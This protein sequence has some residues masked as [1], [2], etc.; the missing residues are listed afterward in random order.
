MWIFDTKSNRQF[1][2]SIQK[3]KKQIQ[4]SEYKDNPLFPPLRT[5]RYY[6]IIYFCSTFV[7]EASLKNIEVIKIYLPENAWIVEHLV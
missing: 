7:N 1:P 2:Y 3:H 6:K 5:D 4:Q